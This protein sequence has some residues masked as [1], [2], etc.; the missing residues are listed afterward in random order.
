MKPIV[1]IG[2]L[3]CFASV[4][5]LSH[6]DTNPPTNLVPTDGAEDVSLMPTLSW[7]WEAPVGCPEGIGI[8]VFTAF[9]GTDPEHSSEVGICCNEG[10]TETV[11][12]LQADTQYFW[13]VRVVDEFW[14]CPGSHEAF[15]VIQSF[16]TAA[17]VALVPTTWVRVKELYN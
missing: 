5:S 13:K 16:T 6:A 17:T 14:D 8:T 12:P 9:L 1:T 10:S 4:A 7:T 2:L 15:S 3:L 11:G